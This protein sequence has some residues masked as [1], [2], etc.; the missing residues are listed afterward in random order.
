MNQMDKKVEEEG[1]KFHCIL[2]DIN[3]V[4]LH[5]IIVISIVFK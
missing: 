1:E 2:T 4:D 5:E 3:G